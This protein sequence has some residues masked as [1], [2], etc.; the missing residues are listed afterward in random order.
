M[1]SWPTARE[2]SPSIWTTCPRRRVSSRS[3]RSADPSISVCLR[4][5]VAASEAPTAPRPRSVDLDLEGEAE[6]DPNHDDHSQDGDALDR[7]VHDD[8]T[9]DVADDEHLEPKQD[10][11]PEVLTEALIRTRTHGRPDRGRPGDGEGPQST[12]H[13]DRCASR[14]NDLHD[15][16]NELLV[17]HR[18]TLSG[19]WPPTLDSTLSRSAV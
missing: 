3:P 1:I 7:R 6:H 8:R 4:R 19:V 2:T 9:D 10:H 16:R 5:P 12:E 13:Q 11:A 15:V 17:G 14:F 18:A